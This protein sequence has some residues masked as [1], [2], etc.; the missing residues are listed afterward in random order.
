MVGRELGGASGRR[1]CFRPLGSRGVRLLHKRQGASGNREGSSLFRSADKELIHSDLYRQLYSDCLSLE[2]GGNTASSSEFHRSANLKMVRE[3]SGSVD[4]TIYHGPSQCFSGLV[5]SSESSFGVRM[6]SQDQS[7]PR[8]LEEVA[9][10][11]RPVCHL[12]QSPMFTIF[13]TIPRS[14]RSGYG[15]SSPELGW[16]A[17]VY[18]FPPWSLI[19]T[20]IKKLLSSSGVLLTIVARY[21]PQRPWFPDLLDLVVDSPVALPQSRDLL[22][23]PHFHRH[24][25]GVSGLSLHAWRLS[26]DLPGLVASLSM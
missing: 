24:H 3:T 10:V 8:A 20:V 23:Q 17:G 4:S 13:F 9:S 12:T 25:L 26:S 16:V 18:A 14:E 1:G 19:P 22:R 21:W 5:I 11:N 6:D 2:S 7:V 15:C